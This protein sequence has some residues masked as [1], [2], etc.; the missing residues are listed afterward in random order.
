M[1]HPLAP[2]LSK[3]KDEELQKKLG[4]L[5]KRIMQCYRFGPQN[6]VPQLQM[7]LDD[8]QNE[9]QTRNAKAME[10]LQKKTKKDFNGIIDIR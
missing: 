9:I 2:D 1:T 6:L 7:L 3:I 10:E 4:D 5:Q 8:Y